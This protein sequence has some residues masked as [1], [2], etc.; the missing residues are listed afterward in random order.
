MPQPAEQNKSIGWVI[1]MMALAV[2]YFGWAFLATEFFKVDPDGPPTANL[3]VNSVA[4]IPNFFR[5]MSYGFSER[6]WMIGVTVG[7]EVGV[8]FLGI[9]MK[10]LEKE[11]WSK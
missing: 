2:L 8:L 7:L 11:L 5:V 4:Q 3:F 6:F 10:K 1:V 9:L